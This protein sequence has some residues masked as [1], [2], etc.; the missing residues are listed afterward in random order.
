[1]Q[2]QQSLKARY[3]VGGEKLKTTSEKL[4]E[5]RGDRTQ[6]Y[7]AKVAG[8]SLSAYKKYENGE[9]IPRDS[10]KKKL[11]DFHGVTIQYLFF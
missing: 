1:M 5:L 3:V 11:A 4:R 6:S 9:R 8:V 10:V 2:G 7:M